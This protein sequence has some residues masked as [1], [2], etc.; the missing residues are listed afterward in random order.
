M[1]NRQIVKLVEDK[2]WKTDDG[3]QTRDGETIAEQG[4]NSHIENGQRT[5]LKLTTQ[6][7][8]SMLDGPCCG[9]LMSKFL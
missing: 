2:C 8:H 7:S 6:S 3:G 9:L 1:A 4:A 5:N